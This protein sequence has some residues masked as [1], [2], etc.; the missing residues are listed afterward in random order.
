MKKKI[1]GIC[2][3]SLVFLAGCTG[4]GTSGSGKG[5]ASSSSKSSGSGFL[6][7]IFNKIPA[8]L[9]GEVNSRVNDATELYGFGAA[10]SDKLGTAA[11]QMKAIDDAKSELGRKIKKEVLATL[12]TYN[13]SL[14]PYT[15]TL[16]KPAIPDLANHAT[17]LSLYNI[18]QKG[19]WEDD[20]KVYALVTAA[21]SDVHNNTKNVFQTFLDNM[22]Q[23]ISSA[24]G[25]M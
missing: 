5:S 17:E 2:I 24:R 20:K 7:G 16:V 23:K 21:K 9:Q 6:S 18:V 22:S 4:L 19:A 13:A 1:I 10:A 3:L 8:E 12:N 15:Q 11:G 25:Q 14:E